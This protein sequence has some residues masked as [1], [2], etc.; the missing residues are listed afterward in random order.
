[1]QLHLDIERRSKQ[2][3]V[4]SHGV[5]IVRAGYRESKNATKI[6]KEQII[7]A[8]VEPEFVGG[9]ATVADSEDERMPAAGIPESAIPTAQAVRE[10]QSRRCF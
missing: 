6:D 7:L 8:N 4:A 3:R 2:G 5:E 1:M 9:Q 10:A